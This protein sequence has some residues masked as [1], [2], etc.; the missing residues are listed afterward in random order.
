MS[1]KYSD[2]ILLIILIALFLLSCDQSPI[3][4][5]SYKNRMKKCLKNTVVSE[6]QVQNGKK[7]YSYDLEVN[8]ILNAL[9][10]EFETTDLS[11]N[12]IRTHDLKGKVNIINFWFT[13]CTPCVKEIPFLN[14]IVRKYKTPSINFLAFTKDTRLQLIDFLQIH[15]FDFKI[16]PE[17][18]NLIDNIFQRTW[19]YPMTIVTDRK[20]K[21][22]GVIND[23]ND[24]V[25][26]F[27]KIDS[28]LTVNQ[29]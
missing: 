17:S 1:T 5:E 8:C 15:P 27:N 24:P 26:V 11:H 6:I 7:A 21:I 29:Y 20:N 4:G 3:D 10:P 23:G 12:F 28:I 25:N 14:A 19:S 18:K 9:L 22:I 16:I 13:N 2:I